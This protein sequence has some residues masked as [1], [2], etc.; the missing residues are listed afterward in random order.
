M[1]CLCA[2]TFCSKCG[3]KAVDE[4]DLCQ[5]IK[6]EKGSKYIDEDGNERI[7]CKVCGSYDDPESNVFIEAS[8]VKNPAFKGAV[9]RDML[10][11][12]EKVSDREALGEEILKGLWGGYSP[13]TAD[14]LSEGRSMFAAEDDK[15]SV[16]M[17]EDMGRLQE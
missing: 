5:H 13:K 6:Y 3:N 16:E 4:T 1:G 10:N 2:Y 11:K 17:K 12:Q 15:G 14:P 7:I 8:W 9:I